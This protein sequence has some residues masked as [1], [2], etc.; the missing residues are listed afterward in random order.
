MQLLKLLTFARC[1]VATLTFALWPILGLAAKPT[2]VK[3]NPIMSTQPPEFF[4][5]GTALEIGRAIRRNDL[6]AIRSLS[7]RA[8]LN[9]VHRQGMTLLFYAVTAQQHSAITELI[10]HG[11]NPHQI[12]R[13]LGSPLDVA[14]Q[15]KDSKTLKAI[16]DGGVSPNTTNSWGTP[17]LFTA[18][19]LDS[20][21]NLKLLVSLKANLDA[22]D[23]N[24]GRTAVYEAV[25][26]GCYDQAAYLIEHGARVDVTTVNGVTLAYSVQWDMERQVPGTPESQKLLRLKRMLQE[27]GIAFPA[28]PPPV[29]RSRM[30]KGGPK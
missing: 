22:K 20:E 5:D 25:S 2:S 21:E 11:A 12:D 19:C 26:K 29:V 23:S 8:D 9:Q 16:L 14:V 10:K 6:E 30:E 17:L 4:F 15:A 18:A 27:R 3:R 28:D 24:L 7:P 1:F 13:E